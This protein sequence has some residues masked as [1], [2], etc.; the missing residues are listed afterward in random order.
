MKQ[1]FDAA[2][3]VPTQFDTAE[4]KAWFAN[5][6]FR[7]IE[8]DFKESLFTERFYRRL[9]HCFFHIAHYNRQGFYSV[10]FSSVQNQLRFLEYTLECWACGDPAFTY[11]DV[12]RAIQQRLGASALIERCRTK[13]QAE[14][15]ARERALLEKLK[16]KYEPAPESVQTSRPACVPI[17]ASQIDL[18]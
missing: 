18:F 4:D 3:F 10:W 7:F 8:G 1:I 6:F 12:K 2:Q 15:E 17:Q 14:T 9:S 13:L 5:H 16:R 11:C